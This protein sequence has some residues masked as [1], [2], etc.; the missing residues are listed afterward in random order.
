MTKWLLGIVIVL[1][2]VA[3]AVQVAYARMA[4]SGEESNRAAT[5]IT[6]VNI[7]MLVLAAVGLVLYF[8]YGPA[9]LRGSK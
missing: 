7:A 5:I 4:R 8:I 3:V 2:G 9:L 6:F 1:I